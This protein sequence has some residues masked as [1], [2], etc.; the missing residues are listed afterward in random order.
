[1]NNIL[2]KEIEISLKTTDPVEALRCFALDLKLKGNNKEEIYN[3]LYTYSLDLTEN[4]R[5]T[6]A[7]ILED[8]LD[9]I[10]GWFVGR[11]LNL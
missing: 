8:V 11:N 4:G 6:D 5:S 1:M 7:E 10:T 3:V 2:Q 9:M